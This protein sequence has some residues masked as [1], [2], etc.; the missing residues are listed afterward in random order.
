MIS[1]FFRAIR[2][3]GQSL[4][5]SAADLQFE[6]IMVARDGIEPPTPPF[7]GCGRF[8]EGLS[9]SRI[10]RAIRTLR[11][12]IPRPERSRIPPKVAKVYVGPGTDRTATYPLLG[13]GATIRAELPGP[14]G[15]VTYVHLRWTG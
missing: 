3:P 11:S 15:W 4:T 7:Q 9:P 10:L 14:F 6:E 1:R 2:A 5:P 8:F 13:P 12:R